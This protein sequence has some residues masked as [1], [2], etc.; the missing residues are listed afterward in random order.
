MIDI[1]IEKYPVS[2]EVLH[3]TTTD[4]FVQY[5]MA[6]SMDKGLQMITKVMK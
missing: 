6:D 2:F 4:C 1:Y 3:K 5:R